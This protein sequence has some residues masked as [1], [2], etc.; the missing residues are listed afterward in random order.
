M[1]G[2]NETDMNLRELGSGDG[3]WI[4]LAQDTVQW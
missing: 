2:W 3:N 4:E 1:G